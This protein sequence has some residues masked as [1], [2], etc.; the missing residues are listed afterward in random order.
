MRTKSAQD[1]RIKFTGEGF[2]RSSNLVMEIFN[3]KGQK[4]A[5]QKVPDAALVKGEWSIQLK[6]MST[7]IY[8][9]KLI[10]KQT[11][12]KTRKFTVW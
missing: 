2:N 6:E 9:I 10:A 12:I 5:S 3:V 1:I 11:T 8:I 7:G 4:I